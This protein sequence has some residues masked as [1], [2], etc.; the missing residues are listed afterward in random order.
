MHKLNLKVWRRSA[1][2]KTVEFAPPIA[3]RYAGR[4]SGARHLLR[5]AVE[6]A[7]APTGKRVLIVDD[8]P[9]FRSLFKVM[10]AQSGFPLSSIREAE[11]SAEAVAFCRED[12]CD[13]LDVVF[14]DLN[15]SRLWPRNG[16]GT[17]Y[18]IRMIRP[19]LPIYMVTADNT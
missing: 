10:L 19:R 6:V 16:I 15:L 8:D 12:Q 3:T 2:M 11:E 4:A 9:N 14:C 17:V 13:P 7:P 1:D 18:V 5:G